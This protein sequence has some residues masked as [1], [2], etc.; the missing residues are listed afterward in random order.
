[1]IIFTQIVILICLGYLFGVLVQWIRNKIATYRLRHITYYTL[2][3]SDGHRYEVAYADRKTAIA[4]AKAMAYS[5]TAYVHTVGNP[6]KRKV[7]FVW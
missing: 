3:S 4:E 7:A 5:G 6:N 2:E 1:M